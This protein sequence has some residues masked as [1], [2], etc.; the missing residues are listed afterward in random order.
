MIATYC[1]DCNLPRDLNLQG[2][3][4]V[5][6]SKQIATCDVSHDLID[7]IQARQIA[8]RVWLAEQCRKSQR[9]YRIDKAQKIAKEAMAFGLFVFLGLLGW[10][11]VLAR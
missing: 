1:L 5:C 11:L 9:M 8:E 2:H 3:C 10:F 7:Y 6:D 4:I